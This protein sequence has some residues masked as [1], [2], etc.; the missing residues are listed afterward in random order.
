MGEG[1]GTLFREDTR[2]IKTAASHR[3]HV[4]NLYHH[5]NYYQGKTTPTPDPIRAETFPTTTNSPALQFQYFPAV[6]PSSTSEVIS[7]QPKTHVLNGYHVDVSST[8][9]PRPA[10]ATIAPTRLHQPTPS[11]TPKTLMN[12]VNDQPYTTSEAADVLLYS[13]STTTTTTQAPSSGQHVKTYQAYSGS[14]QT[15]TKHA[16]PVHA[17]GEFY[18]KPLVEPVYQ[19]AE[20]N[21]LH[22]SSDSLSGDSL[23]SGSTRL[24]PPPAPPAIVVKHLPP[25]TQQTYSPNGQHQGLTTPHPLIYGFKP[26]QKDSYP[27]PPP[28]PPH[29]KHRP[30]R[31][32]ITHHANRQPPKRPPKQLSALRPPLT[33]SFF[34]PS[35][36]GELRTIYSSNS[37]P[38]PHPPLKKLPVAHT[39]P[40][41][42]PL[43]ARSFFKAV[44]S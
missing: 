11:T 23:G 2:A 6:A 41:R 10:V 9:S 19:P 1:A 36:S 38:H 25:A 31:P 43:A 39:K 17:P 34:P 13:T 29:I 3:N 44:F 4:D 22:S 20:G 12:L 30:P 18:Y 5:D 15:P 27:P 14:L 24:P 42:F 37:R 21:S 16:P 8:I 35:N 40:I 28:P 32:V 26:V 7:H 33:N